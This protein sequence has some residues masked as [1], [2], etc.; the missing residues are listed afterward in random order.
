MVRP[1][2]PIIRLFSSNYKQLKDRNR[3][4]DLKDNDLKIEKIIK[5]ID[6]DE[7]FVR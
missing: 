1:C 6:L 3:L 2:H 7:I 5:Y 4:S